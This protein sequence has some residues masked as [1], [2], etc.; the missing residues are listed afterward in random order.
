MSHNK[1]TNICPITKEKEQ[2]MKKRSDICIKDKK[3]RQK[4]THKVKKQTDIS[5]RERN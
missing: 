1:E 5:K 4:I 2:N 3:K